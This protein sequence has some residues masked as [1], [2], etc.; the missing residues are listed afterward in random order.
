MLEY[1]RRFVGYKPL[2]LDLEY[3]TELIYELAFWSGNELPVPFRCES[4]HHIVTP[5]HYRTLPYETK[6]GTKHMWCP[7]CKVSEHQ[8]YGNQFGHV[9]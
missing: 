6:A 5:Q 9:E 4:K 2:G 3:P 1:Q 8:D 7:V